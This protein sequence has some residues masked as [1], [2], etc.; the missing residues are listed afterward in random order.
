M[1]WI[2]F[3]A[4]AVCWAILELLDLGPEVLVIVYANLV[5]IYSGVY[6]LRGIYFAVLER[7][8]VP[9]TV[10]GAAVGRIS[11]GGYTPDIIV[12]P[13][14]GR[15]I[16]NYPGVTG[17]QYCL[18]LCVVSTIGLIT[19]IAMSRGASRR[20]RAEVTAS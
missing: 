6:A 1:V 14:A 5:V 19:A 18:L 11:L 8:S 16:D 10:T 12:A 9:H 20:V 3:G 4:L 2:S 7:T 13:I 17:Y 15:L